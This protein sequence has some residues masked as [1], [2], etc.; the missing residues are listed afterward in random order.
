M[1][2]RP[3]HICEEGAIGRY[4]GEGGD[5]V[6]LGKHCVDAPLG[7]TDVGSVPLVVQIRSALGVNYPTSKG[8]GLSAYEIR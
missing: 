8:R 1:T 5:G 2:C 3:L 4:V 6:R 7:E